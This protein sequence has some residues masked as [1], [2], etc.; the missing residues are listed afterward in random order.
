MKKY[1]EL[2]RLKSEK[3]LSENDLA[4]LKELEKSI[5]DKIQNRKEV[6]HERQD[7]RANRVQR[8]AP[9]AMK[10]RPM[11]A[12]KM[13]RN[14]AFGM[15]GFGQINLA[16]NQAAANPTAA[17]WKLIKDVFEERDGSRVLREYGD[18]GL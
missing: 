16:G 1:R 10:K 15:G 9:R 17:L 12:R 18:Y 3:F 2:E 5:N 13:A 7:R 6:L 14:P 8:R 4:T 11:F